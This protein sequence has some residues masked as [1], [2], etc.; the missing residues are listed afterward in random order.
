MDTRE[1]LKVGTTCAFV[2]LCGSDGWMMLPSVLVDVFDPSGICTVYIRDAGWELMI[3][4]EGCNKF[5]DAPVSAIAVLLVFVID[6]D[7]EQRG[8]L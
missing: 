3:G 6:N 1:C 4:A 8:Q 7:F 5:V 2:A